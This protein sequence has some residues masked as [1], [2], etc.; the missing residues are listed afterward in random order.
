MRTNPFGNI[1]LLLCIWIILRI[2]IKVGVNCVKEARWISIFSHVM[3]TALSPHTQL[4]FCFTYFG[5]QKTCL[6]CDENGSKFFLSMIIII[7]RLFLF[8][9][10]FIWG[11]KSWI[12]FQWWLFLVKLN[13]VSAQRI[14][15]LWISDSI[16]NVRDEL[17]EFN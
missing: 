13:L 6:I 3:P 12:C 14:E 1:L 7:L 10:S 16:D 8:E 17:E 2:Y 11:G 9:V 15:F 4:G 5:P